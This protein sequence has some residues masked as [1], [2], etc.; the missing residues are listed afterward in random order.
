MRRVLPPDERRAELLAASRAVFSRRGY[1]DT[2]ISDIVREVGCS[3][4]TFYNYF[5]GKRDV[6]AEVLEAM[7]QEVTQVIEP[8]DVTRDIPA[9]VRDNIE[10]IIRGI[11]AADVF[12]V[13]F[14]EATGIDDEGNQVLRTFYGRATQ[15]IET[16]LQTGQALGVVR[17]G[18]T[19]VLAWCLLGLL[20]EPVFQARLFEEDI[21]I[22]V[23][24]SEILALIGQGLLKG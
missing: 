23:L 7:M 13:L 5:D 10:R 12:R 1:H 3:R 17:P 22:T 14:T 15:R 21:P 8:I 24:V 4:G 9:Q 20:K 6:F 19:R 18:D 16:A 2:G 11:M